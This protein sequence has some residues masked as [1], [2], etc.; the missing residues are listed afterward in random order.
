MSNII[1][2]KIPAFLSAAGVSL[3]MASLVTG[4]ATNSAGQ[5][6]PA[7]APSGPKTAVQVPPEFIKWMRVNQVNS[8]NLQ[9]EK[10]GT[11]KG[12]LKCYKISNYII[13]S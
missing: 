12:S 2:P 13:C 7:V 10:E 11:F 3:V 8:V 5:V 4:C 9:V 1:S 6:A